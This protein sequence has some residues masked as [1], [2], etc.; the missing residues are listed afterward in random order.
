M[1][2]AIVPAASA[3]RG[4]PV[5]AGSALRYADVLAETVACDVVV[6]FSTPDGFDAALA[7]ASARGL[8]FVSGT[9]GLADARHAALDEA[10]A[11]IPV[12]WASNFSIG[13]AVLRR[14]AAL[15]AASLTPEFDVEII[16]AHHAR[17]LDAPSGTALTLGEAV[18]KARG[19]NLAD[20]ACLARHGILGPRRAG[21][22]GFSSIRAGDLVGE[23]TVLFAG[24]GERLELMHR[25]T[26]R[27]IFARGALYA[28]RWL[29]A[30]AP[31]R[32]DIVDALV[33]G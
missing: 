23:H 33:A 5:A 31:G 11:R 21:S 1:V 22:I 7:A 17:K 27:M 2:A 16:E 8:A 18:A 15:A 25:A 3:L 20:V 29:A 30:R 28:A 14:L 32:Y 6:D 12:L 26:D 19:A 10:A 4:Q 13:A 24:P 9:T